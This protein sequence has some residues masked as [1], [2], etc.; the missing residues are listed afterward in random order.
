LLDGHSAAQVVSR[1]RNHCQVGNA[2]EMS[3]IHWTNFEI[4]RQA[5]GNIFHAEASG[6]GAKLPATEKIRRP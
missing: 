3:R 2:G 4:E 6:E 1:K 5:K